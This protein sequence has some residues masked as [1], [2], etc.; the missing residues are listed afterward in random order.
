M[1]SNDQELVVAALKLLIQRCVNVPYL[2]GA[3]L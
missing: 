2:D 1:T 3:R